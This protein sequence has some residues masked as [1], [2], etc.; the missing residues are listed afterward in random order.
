MILTGA[1]TWSSSATSL[2]GWRNKHCTLPKQGTLWM[3]RCTETRPRSVHVFLATKLQQRYSD[4]CDLTLDTKENLY[5]RKHFPITVFRFVEGN[6]LATALPFRSRLVSVISCWVLFSAFPK[7]IYFFEVIQMLHK[8]V[9]LLTIH[10]EQVL[11][12]V[13]LV[14]MSKMAPRI[15]AFCVIPV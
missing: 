15:S 8:D 11:V 7:L 4:S 9:S 5:A 1:R 3:A 14:T 6:I 2:D 10:S 12:D 13:A